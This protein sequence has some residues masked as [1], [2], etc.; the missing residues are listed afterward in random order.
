MNG[1]TLDNA[2]NEDAYDSVCH[3]LHGRI[4]GEDSRDKKL[5]SWKRRDTHSTLK[6]TLN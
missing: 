5:S 2:L 6:R 3:I 4:I 1:Q